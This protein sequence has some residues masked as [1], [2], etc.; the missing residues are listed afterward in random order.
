M[1]YSIYLY[2]YKIYINVS[3]RLIHGNENEELIHGN[4]NEIEEVL[5][6]QVERVVE[7]VVN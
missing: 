4:E 5:S 3:E 6:K 1:Y 7:K 2:K